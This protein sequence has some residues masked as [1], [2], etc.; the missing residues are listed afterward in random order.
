MSPEEARM[1]LD[2]FADEEAMD[3]EK[4]RKRRHDATVLKDW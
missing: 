3:N 4:K 2:A 1:L